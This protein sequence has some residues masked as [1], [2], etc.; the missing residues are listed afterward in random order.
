MFKVHN[1]NTRKTSMDINSVTFIASE[2]NQ[3]LPNKQVHA[4]IQ[5]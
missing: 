3:N 2:F 5:Q 1:K 4:Q